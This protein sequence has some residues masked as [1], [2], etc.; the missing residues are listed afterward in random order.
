[1]KKNR[2]F[3]WIIAAVLITLAGF[4]VQQFA[5]TVQAVSPNASQAGV[6]PVTDPALVNPLACPFTPEQ[7]RSIHPVFIKGIGHT[8][9]YTNEGPTGVDGGMSM[10]GYCETP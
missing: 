8:V 4:S 1:M 5:A 3:Y 2:W 9:P 7:I 10:L 6:S